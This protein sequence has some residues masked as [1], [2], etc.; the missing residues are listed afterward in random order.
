MQKLEN[1]IQN[2]RVNLSL[3]KDIEEDLYESY[4]FCEFLDIMEIEP[5]F[6][7]KN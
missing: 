5:Y 2:K 6:L 1:K 4:Y 3:L 7:Y